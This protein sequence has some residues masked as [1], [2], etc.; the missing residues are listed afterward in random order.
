MLSRIC[1]GNDS[2]LSGQDYYDEPLRFTGANGDGFLIYPGRVYGIEGPVSSLR[3]EA[4]KDSVE[5]FDLLYELENLVDQVNR[6][7][8]LSRIGIWSHPG[9]IMTI[10]GEEIRVGPSGYYEL[11]ALD[12]ESIGIVATSWADNWTMDYQ[13]NN[14]EGE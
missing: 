1:D 14:E 8:T 6:D 10:N 13:Y 3:M 11:D 5:D 4:I 12:I 7:K 9:L 2:Q